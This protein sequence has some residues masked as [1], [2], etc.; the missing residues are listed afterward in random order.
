MRG[1]L[2]TIIFRTFLHNN[3]FHNH[4]V[5]FGRLTSIKIWN[6]IILHENFLKKKKYIFKNF[7]LL[8][9]SEIYVIKLMMQNN[10]WVY[11]PNCWRTLKRVSVAPTLHV[12]VFA[13]FNIEYT[14]PLVYS[15]YRFI[16]YSTCRF[17]VYSTYRF[18]V[19]F[20][21][22]F[23]VYSIYRFIVNSILYSKGCTPPVGL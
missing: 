9:I 11:H 16:V 22:R 8:K 7:L 3:F 1:S 20:T 15:T 6:N 18:I 13:R 23:I 12:L 19:Y 4:I 17:K 5:N 2:G 10:S 21:Y 14:P